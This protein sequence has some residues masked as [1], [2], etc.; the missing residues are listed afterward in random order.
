MTKTAKDNLKDH[1]WPY[2]DEDIAIIREEK[3]QLVTAAEFA[4]A[5]EALKKSRERLGDFQEPWNER[6]K[7]VDLILS[8]AL[9]EIGGEDE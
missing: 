4:E 9:A 3:T 5:V 7:E 6:E 1:L 2:S 8:E